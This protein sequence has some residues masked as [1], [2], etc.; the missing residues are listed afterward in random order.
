MI[1]SWYRGGR[2]LAQTL[3]FYETDMIKA[4]PKDAGRATFFPNILCKVYTVF[5]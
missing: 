2:G 3:K 5:I 1:Q 4:R